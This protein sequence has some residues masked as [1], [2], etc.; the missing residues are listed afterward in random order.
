MVIVENRRKVSVFTNCCLVYWLT[1]NLILTGWQD[2]NDIVLNDDEVDELPKGSGLRKRVAGMMVEVE[3]DL[4]KKK[5][6]GEDTTNSKVKDWVPPYIVAEFEDQYKQKNL[7][8]VVVLPT[9]ACITTQK[10]LT[11]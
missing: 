3:A 11:L 5:S 10:I 1:D 7:V 2:M 4:K 9:G 8:V 6:N